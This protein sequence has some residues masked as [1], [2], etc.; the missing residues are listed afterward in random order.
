MARQKIITHPHPVLGEVAEPIKVI[1]SEIRELA[2]DMV[3]TMYD[4]PGIGLAANQIGI[5]KRII[6]YDLVKRGDD[7]NLTVLINPEIVSAEGET[8][9]EEACLSVI[10]FSAEVKRSAH[11]RVT[12]LNLDGEEVEVE[13][14]GLF[15]IVLQHEIDHLD[16]KLFIDRLG[17]LRR[18][19]YNR[20][21]KKVLE[22]RRT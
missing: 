9:T 21:L 5:A 19:L 8:S 20:H 11:V 14:E 4:A 18:M 1:D 6:V 16:G 12:G 3:E 13:G 2:G 7:A 17:S 15:A 22:A 10:D